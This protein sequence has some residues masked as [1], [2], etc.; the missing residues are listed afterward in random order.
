MA[1]REVL[2]RL[3]PTSPQRSQSL[4]GWGSLCKVRHEVSGASADL[5]AAQQ[6][7]DEAARIAVTTVRAHLEVSEMP[8][9]VIFVCFDEA[10]LRAYRLALGVEAD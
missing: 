6:A 10:T 1:L 2:E 3:P 5:T 4:V 8:Q 7:F 9:R